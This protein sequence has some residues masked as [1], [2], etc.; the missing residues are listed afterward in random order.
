MQQLPR[1]PSSCRDIHNSGPLPPPLVVKSKPNYMTRDALCDP[2]DCSWPGSFVHGI[3]QARILQWVAICFSRGSSRPRDRTPVSSIT[4]RSCI[5]G[6]FWTTREALDICMTRY[7]HPQP[8]F[9]PSFPFQRQWSLT[10]CPPFPCPRQR[11]QWHQQGTKR[12]QRHSSDNEALGTE[13]VEDGKCWLSDITWGS[14]VSESRSVVSTLW[15]PT[16]YT[17]HG[18]FQAY[19]GVGT[20]PFSRGS[21]QPRDRTQFSRIAGRFFT[22]WATREARGRAANK[23]QKQ[24]N[25]KNPHQLV[26]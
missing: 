14:K 20:F 19:S 17:V 24:T 23:T 11:C 9:P 2:K 4:G 21:S 18:I 15:D 8:G 3:L 1:H 22:R 13:A 26:L 10:Q 16:D 7:M 6:R 25:K 12:P 5:A